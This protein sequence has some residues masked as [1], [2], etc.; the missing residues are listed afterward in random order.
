MPCKIKTTYGEITIENDVIARMAGLAALDCYG[1]VGM[2][3]R[4]VKDGI[5]QLLKKESLTRGI[6]IA[7]SGTGESVTIG[8]HIIVLYGTNITAISESLIDSVVYSVEEYSGIKV[9][10][11]SV[12]VECIQ[13]DK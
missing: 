2:A 9:D 12:F 6:S 3:A 4:N 11:V 1:I 10:K 8:L 7:V 5:V 13:V